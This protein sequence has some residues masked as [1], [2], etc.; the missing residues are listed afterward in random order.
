MIT[1]FWFVHKYGIGLVLVERFLLHQRVV[2]AL[3]RQLV[4]YGVA[5]HERSHCVLDYDTPSMAYEGG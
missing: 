1:P 3:K 4:L 5:Y 2:L